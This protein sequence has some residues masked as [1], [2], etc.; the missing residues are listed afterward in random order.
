MVSVPGWGRRSWAQ[1]P[2]ISSAQ[3]AEAVQGP[4]RRH[5]LRGVGTRSM[6]LGP[7]SF[8]KFATVG[9]RGNKRQLVLLYKGVLLT[10]EVV[11]TLV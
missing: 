1:G 4:S 6:V 3:R 5:W 10:R 7:G 2:R 8:L 9:F 11:Y